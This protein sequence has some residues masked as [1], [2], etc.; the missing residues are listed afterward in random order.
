MIRDGYVIKDGKL[1][2]R[3]VWQDAH[4]ALPRGW[5]VHHVNFVKTDNDLD[6][7]VALPEW[8]HDD[9]HTQMRDECFKFSKS[10]L[11]PLYHEYMGYYIKNVAKLDALI[12]CLRKLGKEFNSAGI[13]TVTFCKLIFA[14]MLKNK[15]LK[16]G[17]KHFKK[18]KK[19]PKVP[20][21]PIPGVRG[22]DRDRL[23]EI[24]QLRKEEAKNRKGLVDARR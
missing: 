14:R 20:D 7:L 11:M 10:Q 8:L 3:T 21:K 12:E 17:K 23:A 9:L 13:S 22:S 16:D 19:K 5:V 6:N 18:I 2:H 1:L 4:G 15:I 24:R